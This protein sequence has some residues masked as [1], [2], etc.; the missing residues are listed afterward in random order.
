MVGVKS[1][2]GVLWGLGRVGMFL[3][4]MYIR[5]K[6]FIFFLFILEFTPLFCNHKWTLAHI[7]FFKLYI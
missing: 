7:G 5:Y 2:M 1:G 6:I 3:F 4:Y